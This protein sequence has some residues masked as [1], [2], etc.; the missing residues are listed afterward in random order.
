MVSSR[1]AAIYFENPTCLGT[2]ESQGQEIS[3]IAH[4][5]GAISIVGVDPITLGVLTPP[6][7][8]GADIVVGTAQTLGIH[9]NCG[10]GTSGFIATRDEEQYVAE[11]PL[12]LISITDTTHPGE[13]AFGQCAYERTSY[14]SREKAKDW[15][16]TVSGLWTITAS[17]YMALMGPQGFRDIGRT[18]IQ[19]THY[20]IARISELRGVKILF[21]DRAFREF[22]VNF[23]GAGRSVKEVND[24]LLNHQVFGG[25]DLSKDFPELG[26]SALYCV[27]EI[28][29]KND[30]DRLV[31]TLQGVL[32][33]MKKDIKLRRYHSPV[34]SE[35]V[36]M[37]M[38]HPGERGVLVPEAEEE[39]Q[40]RVG[41]AETHI[42]ENMRRKE[43]PKLPEISQLQALRHYL[44]LSQENLGMD[45]NIEL[46]MGTATMKYS[47]KVNE[48]LARS[49][50]M[51]EIHPYQDERT[52][53]GILEIMYRLGLFLCRYFRTGPVRFPAFG[54]RTCNVY[55]CL[56][57]QS[58]SCLA[59]RARAAK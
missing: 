6:S 16:G 57:V 14:M 27:T 31:S 9:M 1:T 17:V 29:T 41:Q 4:R 51:T 15:V 11:N 36:I 43:L 53:Q 12:F 26:N 8:Y 32:S 56:P 30:I 46:G 10:G 37:E 2:I 50:Q 42:P 3:D 28:H 48:F 52:M 5:Q 58:L 33:E 38:G 18:I 45:S 19:K 23:D 54:G 13:Y 7:D 20:A 25:K 21:G 55:Q 35:P 40:A 34:W 59:G 39:V 22:V 49:P 47:P 24:A 44:H